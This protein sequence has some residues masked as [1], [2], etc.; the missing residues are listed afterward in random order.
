MRGEID[1]CS[2]K[3]I[4][5]GTT[6]RGVRVTMIE[7]KN[8]SEPEKDIAKKLYHPPAFRFEQVFEVSAL[9]CGKL[10]GGGPGSC[11]AQ[12]LTTKNS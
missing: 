3:V 5:L 9:A 1:G 6:R 11:G 2:L 12:H 10:P 4:F 7:N 8:S